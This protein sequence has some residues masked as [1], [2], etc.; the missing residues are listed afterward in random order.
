MRLTIDRV[1]GSIPERVHLRHVTGPPMWHAPVGAIEQMG[2]ILTWLK[3]MPTASPY[4]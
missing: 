2:A 1:G 4:A 3:S